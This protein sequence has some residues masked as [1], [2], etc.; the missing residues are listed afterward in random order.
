MMVSDSLLKEVDDLIFSH[1]EPGLSPL[2]SSL[3]SRF[4][5]SMEAVIFYGSCLQKANPYDGLVDLYVVVDSYVNAYRNPVAALA[6]WLLPPNVYYLEVEHGGKIIRTKYAVVSLAHFQKACSEKWYHSSFWARF[7]QPVSVLFVKNM[8]IRS[9]VSKAVACA[10][11]T[12][13]KRVIPCVGTEFDVKTLFYRGLLLSYMAEL[14][15]ERELRVKGLVTAGMKWFRTVTPY[16][17]LCTGYEVQEVARPE[18][19]CWRVKIDRWMRLRCRAEWC[20]RMVQGKVLS[21]LRLFKAA[22]T[23]AGGVDYA[24][25]KIER[26]SGVKIEVTPFMRRHPVV[27]LAAL[28]WK[29]WRKGGVR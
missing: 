16:A 29:V 15:P 23:F 17:I 21:V 19:G 5:A 2:V 18:T 24:I 25:W 26:H 4:G 11:V 1:P 12:F 28:W 7:A 14:R 8:E 9:A 20:V 27:A 22:F 6:N 13:L 10:V 3:A